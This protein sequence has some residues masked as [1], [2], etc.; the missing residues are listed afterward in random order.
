[1]LLR[2]S[3]GNFQTRNRGICQAIRDLPLQTGDIIFRMNY[4]KIFGVP[5]GHL[6]GYLTRSKYVHASIVLQEGHEFF[7]MNLDEHGTQKQ[8]LS[9]WMSECHGDEVSIYRYKHWTPDL[10]PQIED[11][12]RYYLKKNYCYNFEF[13]FKAKKRMYCTQSVCQIYE[14]LGI[15]LMEPIVLKKILTKWDYQW[16]VPVNWAVHEVFEVGFP[17]KYPLYFVGN[18]HHGMLA[19]PLLMPVMKVEIK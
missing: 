15:K 11:K 9:F 3:H 8:S 2:I 18:E 17:T 6:V 14:D 10:L 4:N 16:F 19:S 12:I 13:S 5:F 1:M 7:L